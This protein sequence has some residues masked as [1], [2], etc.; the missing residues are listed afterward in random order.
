M[1]KTI[2]KNVDIYYFL[3][4]ISCVLFIVLYGNYRCKKQDKINDKS[5]FL[6]GNPIFVVNDF[7]FGR[8]HIAHILF[9][10]LLGYLYPK[11]FYLTMFGGIC[12]EIVEFSLGYFKPD[13][14]YNNW[15][16]GVNSSN[17][18]WYYQYSDI[19]ANLIGFL[20]GMN[21]SKII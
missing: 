2:F 14:F 3:L 17:E 9:Y 1:F 4:I 7:K 15:C 16:H 21:L 5:L 13:W 11:S 19:F 10:G 8:W 20:I 6:D 18:W 12:W